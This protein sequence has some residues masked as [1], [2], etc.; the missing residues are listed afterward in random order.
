MM[1]DKASYEKGVADGIKKGALMA[2]AVLKAC[3]RDPKDMTRLSLKVTE[4]LNKL[5]D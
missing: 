2:V 4:K 3:E 5:C 1:M